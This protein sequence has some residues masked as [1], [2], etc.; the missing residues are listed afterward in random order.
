MK[1]RHIARNLG[2]ALGGLLGVA[3]LPAASAF[4]DVYEVVPDPSDT[5]IETVTGF[6]GLGNVSAPPAVPGTVQG[7]QL[8][9]YVDKTTGQ[10]VGTFY[11]Y[12][13]LDQLN[14]NGHLYLANFLVTQDVTGTPGT[15]FGDLPNPGSVIEIQNQDGNETIYTDLTSKTGA[16]DAS[17]QTHVTA[18]GGH[19][20]HEG[21]D[22]AAGLGDNSLGGSNV[23]FA[24][25]NVTLTDGYHFV[26]TGG[27]NAENVTEI[28]G[29]MP[30]DIDVQGNREFN[31]VGPTGEVL[32]QFDAVRD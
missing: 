6:Y 7:E 26:P 32:G 31:L 23:P 25:S 28:S 14:Q 1:R 11:G 17:Y 9:D 13:S 22:P 29:R 20:Y 27:M 15:K 3:Y 24:D 16:A 8:F 12:E 5:N 18:F 19:T 10:T 30:L 2:A 4:A 21:F